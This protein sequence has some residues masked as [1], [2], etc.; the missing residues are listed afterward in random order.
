MNDITAQTF[1]NWFQ[2]NNVK[3]L[4]IHQVEETEK[5]KLLDEFLS[6]LHAYCKD[7]FFAIGGDPKNDQELIITAE[8]RAEHFGKVEELVSAAPSLKEWRIIAFKPPMGFDFKIRYRDIEFDPSR[9]W[10]LPM[11]SATRPAD[12]GLM[13]SYADYD[14]SKKQIYLAGTQ[15]LL[16]ES[17]GEREAAVEISYLQVQKLPEDPEEKG[18]IELKELPNY[19]SWWKKQSETQK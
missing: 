1:W 5:E 13:V 18:Y 6:Q 12:L 10:F 11:Q 2:M 4:F 3:Y 8:G 19:I 9:I 17:L 7:L 16:N 15:L 14:A